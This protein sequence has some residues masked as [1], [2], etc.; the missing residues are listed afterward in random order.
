[1]YRNEFPIKADMKLSLRVPSITV[2]QNDT[3]ANYLVISLTSN[4]VPVDISNSTIAVRFVKPDNNTVEGMATILNAEQGL[5][6]YMIGTNEIALLGSV[7]GMVV[8]YGDDGERST[9]ITQFRLTIKDDYSTDEDVISKTEFPIL[10]DLVSKTTNFIN[11]ENQRLLNEYNRVSDFARMSEIFQESAKFEVFQSG[12]VIIDK[13]TSDEI[14]S[15]LDFIDLQI[16]NIL[17]RL[18]ALEG[19]AN[20]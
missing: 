4:T 16:D 17:Q 11:N 12:E 10:T 18:T 15:K 8:I 13:M 1:L 7:R 20:L 2:V 6:E 5:V 9:S 14:L 3:K 19:K